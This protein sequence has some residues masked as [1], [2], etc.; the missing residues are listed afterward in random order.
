MFSPAV[1]SNISP[2]NRRARSPVFHRLSSK[3]VDNLTPR[4]TPKR[5]EDFFS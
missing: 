1:R 5:A 2:E 4:V 3:A